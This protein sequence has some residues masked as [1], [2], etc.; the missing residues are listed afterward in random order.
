MGFGSM[1]L[2]V[3]IFHPL[4]LPW[5]WSLLHPCLD[6]CRR[7]CSKPGSTPAGWCLWGQSSSRHSF[8]QKDSKF[9]PFNGG[10]LAAKLCSTLATPWT[11][12]HQASL[13]VGFSSQ[14]YW[15]G[16]SLPSPGDHPGPGIKR[17]SSALK[18]DSLLLSQQGSP[19]S[20]G[21]KSSSI[22]QYFPE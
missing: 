10:G 22:F 1:S 16:W 17:E 4:S 9:S 8:A 15:R 13:S 3:S 19:A 14:E 7:C 18:A 21:G 11:V 12:V 5:T 20:S 2:C 6:Y